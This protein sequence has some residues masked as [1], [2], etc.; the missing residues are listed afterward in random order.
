VRSS[1]A[2]FRFSSRISRADSDVTPPALPASTSA[3]RTPT[4]RLRR[5][6]QPARHRHDRRPLRVVILNMLSDQTDRL[7]PGLLVVLARHRCH[8][9]NEGGVHQTRGGS[10]RRTGEGGPITCTAA[11]RTSALRR[12]WCHARDGTV[13]RPA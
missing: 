2:F 10:E 9:P 1:S 13:S 6:P 8:L 12:R 5:H 3:W 11:S 7:G 4:Q